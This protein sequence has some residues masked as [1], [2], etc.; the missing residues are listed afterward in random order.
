[1]HE[2][3][4]R[5]LT[6]NVLDL[7]E[8]IDDTVNY[9]IDNLFYVLNNVTLNNT[10]VFDEDNAVNNWWALIALVL[11]V[12]T[13]AGNVLVCLAIYL[14][15][16][17][18]NVTNYFLMSLAITDL[19]VA[20]LVMPL[21]ILT[22]LRGEFEFGFRMFFFRPVGNQ[23]RKI[24]ASELVTKYIMYKK[25]QYQNY[26]INIVFNIDNWPLPLLF[27]GQNFCIRF[28]NIAIVKKFLNGNLR[29]SSPYN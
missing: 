12:C 25:N 16:R 6:K 22:L 13:A 9:T 8:P 7:S 14:E 11:V 28:T 20:I 1:M 19:L 23:M 10:N 24:F 2:H 15:R 3:S 4:Y 18:Q 17:L 26:T 5:T 27:K 21:G 29:P